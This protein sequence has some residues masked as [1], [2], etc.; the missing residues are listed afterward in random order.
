[1]SEREPWRWCSECDV[2]W[3]GSER[4]CWSCGRDSSTSIGAPAYVSDYGC[5]SPQSPSQ[6]NRVRAE[7]GLP[8]LPEDASKQSPA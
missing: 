3:V 6:W 8:P 4:V 5:G 2:K 7:L 1:M